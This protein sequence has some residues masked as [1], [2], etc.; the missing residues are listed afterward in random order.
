M[1][2]K[3][4][5]EENLLQLLAPK[6]LLTSSKDK[7]ILNVLEKLIKKHLIQNIKY[8]IFLDRIDEMSEEELDAVA[9]EIHVDFYDYT[10]SIEKKREACKT[11]FAIHSIKGTPAAIKRILNIFFKDSSLKQWY[12]YDGVPGRFK[13]EVKGIAPYNLQEI[14]EKIEDAKKKSQ[15]LEKL[16]FLAGGELLLKSAFF[17]LQNQSHIVNNDTFV[18]NLRS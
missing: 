18:M 4:I 13:V 8:L 6:I 15:H 14:A 12:E 3:T 7:I 9:E 2:Y 1:I 16:E 11:S 10:L 5:Y 17:T